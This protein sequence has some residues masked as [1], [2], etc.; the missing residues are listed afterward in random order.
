VLTRTEFYLLSIPFIFHGL[1]AFRGAKL[2]FVRYQLF[3]R[4][5]CVDQSLAWPMAQW[6][7]KCVNASAI[8]SSDAGK[9]FFSFAALEGTAMFRAV[10]AT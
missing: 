7:A 4:G 3:A 2:N 6:S 1:L 8:N 10:R 5:I 9:G